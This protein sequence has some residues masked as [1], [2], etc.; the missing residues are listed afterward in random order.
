MYGTN[1]HIERFVG[2]VY[3]YTAFLSLEQW[4][5]YT[6]WFKDYNKTNMKAILENSP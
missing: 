2:H 6:V 4:V 1:F 3:V 5:N